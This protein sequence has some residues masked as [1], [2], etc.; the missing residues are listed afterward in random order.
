LSIKFDLH[1]KFVGGGPTVIVVKNGNV[2]AT[3]ASESVV[4]RIGDVAAFVAPE[5]N[6]ALV[7]RGPVRHLRDRGRI[8]AVLDD[9]QLPGRERLAGNTFDRLTDSFR[10]LVGEHDDAHARQWGG[11]NSRDTG[12][13]KGR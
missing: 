4:G 1:G 6:D 10:T 3:R 12:S 9:D 7:A 13:G 5:V 11:G 8:V 2:F